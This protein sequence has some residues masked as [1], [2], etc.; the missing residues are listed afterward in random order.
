MKLDRNQTFSFLSGLKTV[1]FKCQLSLDLE[2]FYLVLEDLLC[3]VRSG[4]LY[5]ATRP[6]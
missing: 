5:R 1:N 3:F 4:F 2:T 6:S